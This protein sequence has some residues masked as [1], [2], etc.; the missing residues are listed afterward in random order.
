MSDPRE[1]W[2]E[3]ECCT[4]P[5]VGR[6]W[7]EHDA[8][9]DCEDGGK[10]TKYV[11]ATELTDPTDTTSKAYQF[12]ELMAM[13]HGDGGHYLQR[14]G[15][16]KAATDAIAKW[17]AMLRKIEQMETKSIAANRALTSLALELMK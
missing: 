4:D 11:L 13:M 1:V 2:L 7:C 3:P 12:Q 15:A 10:W 5:S 6:I 8:P 14:H 9:F 17:Y 16:V